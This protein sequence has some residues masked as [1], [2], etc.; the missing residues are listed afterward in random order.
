MKTP[1]VVHLSIYPVDHISIFQKCC[2]SEVAEGYRV[3]QIVCH[4]GDE[5]VD[6]VEIQ[7]SLD[8]RDASGA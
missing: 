6:G 3:T 4:E 2:K 8:P 7:P 1:H 5:I